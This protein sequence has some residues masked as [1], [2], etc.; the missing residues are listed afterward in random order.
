MRTSNKVIKKGY[1]TEALFLCLLAVKERV[2]QR[3]CN[4]LLWRNPSDLSRVGHERDFV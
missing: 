4:F 1:I 2:H 3:L